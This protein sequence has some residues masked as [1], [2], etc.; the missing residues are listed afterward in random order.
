MSRNS[1]NE[2]QLLADLAMMQDR[3]CLVKILSLHRGNEYKLH[4]NQRQRTLAHTLIDNG[5]DLILGGH[6]HVP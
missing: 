2:E 3:G 4:P 5:A 1:L 6:S